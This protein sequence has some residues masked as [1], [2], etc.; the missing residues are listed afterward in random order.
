[1][2]GIMTTVLIHNAK[3]ITHVI[4]NFPDLRASDIKLP[5]SYHTFKTWED[6]T[7]PD[8]FYSDGFVTYYG[9]ISEEDEL[10]FVYTIPEKVIDFEKIVEDTRINMEI[11]EYLITKELR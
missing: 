3:F 11:R 9:F 7:C 8:S 1:M 6:I 4:G 5:I 10:F 2:D